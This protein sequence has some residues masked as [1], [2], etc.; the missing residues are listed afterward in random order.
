[1]QKSFFFSSGDGYGHHHLLTIMAYS[2]MDGQAE[3][4]WVAWSN[5]KMICLQMITHP[6]TI[7]QLN[8]E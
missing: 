2:Q 6:S 8:V 7:N 5:T 1:M 3:L 4:A